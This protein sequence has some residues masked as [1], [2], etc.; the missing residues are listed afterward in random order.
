MPRVDGPSRLLRKGNVEVGG[1]LR[2]IASDY[3]WAVPQTVMIAVVPTTTSPYYLPGGRGCNRS[4]GRCRPRSRS[5]GLDVLLLRRSSEKVEKSR[6]EEREGG[7]YQSSCK[8]KVAGSDQT[9]R[10]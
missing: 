7:G 5:L 8:K 6:G 10:H 3:S 1:R 2:K 4:L 9:A